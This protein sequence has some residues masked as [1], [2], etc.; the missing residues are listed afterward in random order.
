MYLKKVGSN[1]IEKKLKVG[2]IINSKLNAR[3]PCKGVAKEDDS[4]WSSLGAP[5]AVD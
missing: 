4:N 2:V 1:Y 3:K 5:R